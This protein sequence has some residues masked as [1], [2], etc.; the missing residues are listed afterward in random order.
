MSNRQRRCYH[1]LTH[2]VLVLGVNSVEVTELF[3]RARLSGHS[4]TRIKKT[5]L[6]AGLVEMVGN[7]FHTTTK[8]KAWL[9]SFRRVTNLMGAET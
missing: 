6:K 8:G 2:D 9:R 1:D 5:L 3:W 7:K 4:Y